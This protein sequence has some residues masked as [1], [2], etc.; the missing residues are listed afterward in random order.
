[1]NL[2]NGFAEI[3]I[4][5]QM[6]GFK[7]GWNSNA[8]FCELTGCKLSELGDKLRDPQPGDLR[9]LFF[10]AYRA[11]CLSAKIEAAVDRWGFGDWMDAMKAD[12]FS[13]LLTAITKSMP[14]GEEGEKKN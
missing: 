4:G 6:R 12:D 5:G 2:L 7:F 10:S 13:M 9:D 11:N 3:E 1:M 14:S 8:I